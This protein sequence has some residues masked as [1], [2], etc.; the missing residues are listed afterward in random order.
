M[1][2]AVTHTHTCIHTCVSQLGGY[3]RAEEYLGLTMAAL[4]APSPL[5]S[6]CPV[7]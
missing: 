7:L 5:L 4:D 6:N 1:G 3:G 2:D